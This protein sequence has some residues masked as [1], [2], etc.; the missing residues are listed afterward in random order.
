A[1][2]ER[3]AP[4]APA[5]PLL[6]RTTTRR[7]VRRLGYGGSVTIYAAPEGSVTVEA[8]P[9]PEVEITAEV[10]LSADTEEE[11][12]RLAELNG[13]LLDE[14]SNH[15]RVVTTGTHDRKFIKRAARGLPKKLLGMPWKIDYR[16][17]VPAACDLELYTGR[18]ALTLS[19]VEG[20]LRL[21]AGDGPASLTLAGGDVEATLRGGPVTVRVPARSWRGRGLSVRLAS[22]DLTVELPAN[23][24][25]DVN[26]E[27]LRAGR[28]VNDH[29]GLAPRERTQPTER[30]LRARAGHGG[31]TLSFTVGDG[32]LRIRQEGTGRQ[33]F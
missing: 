3:A 19:G 15:V 4:T 28:V 7:E 31:A 10:E 25:G 11:L 20:A 33:N 5:A 17:R 8:W 26:A 13:F 21:N 1:R 2:P 27:V 6:K 24:S 18:G 14:D 22:G 23:F 30:S 32:T 29:A 12:A 16:V 9:R